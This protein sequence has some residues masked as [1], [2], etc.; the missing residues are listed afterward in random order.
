MEQKPCPVQTDCSTKLEE[1]ELLF[2]S[3]MH[4][5]AHEFRRC[6]RCRLIYHYPEPS[7]TELQHHYINYGKYSEPDYFSNN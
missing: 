2:T 6:N 5:P 3:S 1:Y 4:G 7:A